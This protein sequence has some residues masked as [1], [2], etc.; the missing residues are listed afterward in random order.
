MQAKD[1][2]NKDLYDYDGCDKIPNHVLDGLRARQPRQDSGVNFAM[3]LDTIHSTATGTLFASQGVA[4]ASSQRTEDVAAEQQPDL[5]SS[6]F[7]I[8]DVRTE[9]KKSI[10]T[11]AFNDLRQWL[12]A[13]RLP[14]EYVKGNERS[15]SR[16]SDARHVSRKRSL[17]AY[18][19]KTRESIHILGDWW[20]NTTEDCDVPPNRASLVEKNSETDIDS[21]NERLDL[22]SSVTLPMSPLERTSEWEER[23]QVKDNSSN[24]ARAWKALKSHPQSSGEQSKDTTEEAEIE[25]QLDNDLSLLQ[26]AQNTMHL[27]DSSNYML[28]RMWDLG[29]R[30]RRTRL[31]SNLSLLSRYLEQ[32]LSLIC[33]ICKRVEFLEAGR[34]NQSMEAVSKEIRNLKA[35]LRV[36]Q[37]AE[38]EYEALIFDFLGWAIVQL[39]IDIQEHGKSTISTIRV[40]SFILKDWISPDPRLRQRFLRLQAIEKS[41][42]PERFT[43]KS[44]LQIQCVPEEKPQVRVHQ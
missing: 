3:L 31:Y 25:K 14:T 32:E 15:H 20:Y 44:S 9:R 28:P 35:H 7:A 38:S 6:I 11:T 1:L 16:D 21:K 37:E 29:D 24:S 13:F 2:S 4:Q 30:P 12:D 17:S 36:R 40:P 18:A 39:E 26:A 43:R 33:I 41:N 27:P 23:Q 42:L 8:H 5:E 34:S 19:A 22:L 10:V